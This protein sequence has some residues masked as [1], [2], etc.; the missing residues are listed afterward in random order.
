MFELMSKF[1]FEFFLPF[2]EVTYTKD[3]FSMFLSPIINESSFK[4]IL[5]R[6]FVT[7]KTSKNSKIPGIQKHNYR[8]SGPAETLKIID[9]ICQILSRMWEILLIYLL[10]FP[11]TPFQNSHSI[12]L[13]QQ[14]VVKEAM[15]CLYLSDVSLLEKGDSKILS[16][17]EPLCTVVGHIWPWIIPDII[18]TLIQKEF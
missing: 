13:Q 2:G 16:L 10:Y 17:S 4:S 8:L 6:H 3:N 15:I 1:S 7:W 9:S 5:K 18:D 14:P 12:I 11:T